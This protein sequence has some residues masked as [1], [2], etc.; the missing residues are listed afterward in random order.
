MS[1]DRLYW[2][3]WSE[4]N[5]IGAV[6]LKRIFQ[7]FGSL[8]SAWLA[9]VDELRAVEGIGGKSLETIKTSREKI[10]PR[11]LL[12]SHSRKNPN[13]WTPADE[14][15]PKLLL[16]IPSPPPVLY[17]RGEVDPLE[18]G[19]IT[20][21]IG[22]VGTRH[23]SE[24]GRS[25]TRRLSSALAKAGFRVISGMAE[26]VD[27]EAH[28]SCLKNRQRTIAVL[29]T[30]VD[31]PYPSHHRSLHQEIENNGLIL[32]E[33]PAGTRPDKANFPPRNRIIAALSR[34]VLVIEAPEKSGSLI[35]ARYANE[36]GKD[37][38][39]LPNS[40]DVFSARGCLGLIRQGAEIILSESD[41]LEMLGSMPILETPPPTPDLEPRLMNL[42]KLL[43]N[44]TVSF[45]TL[46]EQSQSPPP[47]VAGILLELELMGLIMQLPGMRYQKQ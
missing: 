41:L 6:L 35:T 12:E 24:H 14:D 29:G 34:A 38:Y 20:P 3:A 40:P 2:L 44:D 30:G 32:S 21:S 10:N 17:Y 11:E 16:E 26:G 15:Y 31:V 45:D 28:W 22:I 47:E 27:G 36:F 5:G 33:Y 42:Y 23:P 19:G 13:F 18:N 39:V 8:E 43:D 1:S 7:H 25:W 46:V 9:P 4:I 37:V